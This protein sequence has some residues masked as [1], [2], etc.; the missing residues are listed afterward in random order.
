MKCEQ[1]EKWY[2]G[3]SS[4][5]YGLCLEEDKEVVYNDETEEYECNQFQ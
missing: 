3:N 1:C 4:S 2:T 5:G